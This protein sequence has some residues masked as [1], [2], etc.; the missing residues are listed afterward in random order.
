LHGNFKGAREIQSEL[1]HQIAADFNEMTSVFEKD[2][3]K[4]DAAI[5]RLRDALAGLHEVQVTA[6]KI[7]P[8]AEAPLP[9]MSS[10]DLSGLQQ[11]GQAMMEQIRELMAN[12]KST[13]SELLAEAVS[14]AKQQLD[15]KEGELKKEQ[16]AVDQAYAHHKM[17]AKQDYAD[18]VSIINQQWEAQQA[19]YK[20]L[21]GLYQSDAKAEAA[22]HAQEEAEHQKYLT[23]L[24]KAQDTY[25]QHVLAQWKW[26]TEGMK[27]A[28][29]TAVRDMLTTYNSFGKDM[30]NMMISI[31][32]TLIN[33]LAEWVAQWIEN[34]IL[35]KI[36]T[37]TTAASQIAANAGV[38]AS[39]SMASVA[40][41]P[42]VGWAMAPGVGAS[43][44]AEALSY[45]SLAA[46]AGGWEVPED[47]LAY[48]HKDEK[49]LPPSISRG[50][51]DLISSGGAGGGGGQTLHANV[52]VSAVDAK[53]FERHMSDPRNREALVRTLSKA[54]NRGRRR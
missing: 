27:S 18:T 44:L 52:A 51:N 25:N 49:I 9:D 14:N 4:G 5:S 8:G 35:A 19:Y 29:S 11:Q 1:F 46:A 2:S 53:S 28:L 22:V 15:V 54:F 6:K 16:N 32:D 30:E 41:I 12:S 21:E 36:T 10:M 43:T 7:N 26:A 50:L 38:A 37:Q 45:E 23:Q 17:S 40:A 31:L 47:Q 20:N 48:V 42:Y 13:L 34:W 39:A 33:K 3:A 24:E